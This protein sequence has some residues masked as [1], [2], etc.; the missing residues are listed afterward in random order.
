MFDGHIWST[1]LK[2]VKYWPETK[3]LQK[4][5]Y[6]MESIELKEAF[7]SKD[8]M[9][10]YSRLLEGAFRN[11]LDAQ[12]VSAR[13][14][15]IHTSF[16][17]GTYGSYLDKDVCKDMFNTIPEDDAK[18]YLRKEVPVEVSITPLYNQLVSVSIKVPWELT[19]RPVFKIDVFKCILMDR[20]YQLGFKL[21]QSSSDSGPYDDPRG[22]WYHNDYNIEWDVRIKEVTEG[23][24]EMQVRGSFD[25]EIEYDPIID[26]ASWTSEWKLTGL[27]QDG[28]IR[29]MNE[30]GEVVICDPCIYDNDI[31]FVFPLQAITKTIT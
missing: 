25:I 21:H 8:M 15:V 1:I 4:A 10:K 18:K 3:N 5:S 28:S 26:V 6:M 2:H 14:P 30:Y 11:E 7:E 9:D 17:L 29:W 19:A 12:D 23:E 27:Y 24:L 13:V 20:P 16:D 22:R 31:D